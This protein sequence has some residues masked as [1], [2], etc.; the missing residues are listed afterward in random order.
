MTHAL[1]Q[2]IVPSVYCLGLTIPFCNLVLG[3]EGAGREDP[4]DTEV[5]PGSTG[6]ASCSPASSSAG[7][8]PSVAAGEGAVAVR[9]GA[10][11]VAVGHHVL[12]GQLCLATR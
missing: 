2:R 4:G 9:L 1:H 10:V 12:G 5:P 6:E 7:L 3:L 8:L 11:E